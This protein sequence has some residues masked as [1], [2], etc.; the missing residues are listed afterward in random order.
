MAYC[1]LN[2]TGFAFLIRAVGVC[3]TAALGA[4]LLSLM[5]LAP[6]LKGEQVPA[7]DAPAP[8]AFPL[9][10]ASALAVTGGK[11]EPVE[12]LG[13]KAIR[14]TTASEDNDIFAYVNGT[15]IQDG[16][17]DVDIAVKITTPPGVRMPGFTGI[18]FR[19][20][21][22]GS[23]YEMFYL[24]P[25]NALAE[26]QAMRN[27]AVQY[28]A[29]PGF[30][31][32]PLR[33][34]WPFI[35]E[36]WADLKPESWTHVHV[37]VHGRRA[38]LFLNGSSS[39]SLIVNGLKG[40]DLHGGVALWGYPGEES[41]FSNLRVTPERPLPVHNGSDA[42]GKWHVV[43]ASDYGR[44]EGSLELHREGTALSGTWTGQFGNS[45]PVTGT[46]RDGYVELTFTANWQEDPSKP[47]ST[48]VMATLAGWIDDDSA[49]G[50]MKVEG[51]ADGPWSA[52]RSQ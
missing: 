19:A 42:S 30:D 15:A 43:F 23:H 21:P 45:L 3:A 20:R 35:Y 12:Y 40:E 24:R 5:A 38:R 1:R 50:R 33:R 13:R 47:S 29:K 9:R 34:Q 11:A 27:H 51:R 49:A 48:A 10:D 25:R 31:W 6:A 36:S 7:T 4:T 17:I 14:L 16:A 46:W 18:A 52:Q 37:E 8:Q 32:Y 26:D 44:Y 22:D 2:L 41:Y 28:I 39:P